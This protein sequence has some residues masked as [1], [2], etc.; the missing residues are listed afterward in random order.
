MLLHLRSRRGRVRMPVAE[1]FGARRAADRGGPQA[2]ASPAPQ[3]WSR[4][5]DLAR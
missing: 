3:A 2:A 5:S 4:P 1:C